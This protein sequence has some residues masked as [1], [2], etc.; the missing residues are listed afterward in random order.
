M[1]STRF[2]VGFKNNKEEQELLEYLEKV[3]GVMGKSTYLKVLLKQ[4]ME[5]KK[6]KERL[7]LRHIE[8]V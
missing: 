8:E 3:S 6:L 7:K 2:L 5:K 1:K 4:D